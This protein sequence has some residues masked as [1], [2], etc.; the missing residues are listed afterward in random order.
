M[1]SRT[2]A[3]LLAA[4]ALAAGSA[5]AQGFKP[6]RPVELV[7][8]TGPGG[9]SDV[10]ARA[11]N[12]L[13]ESGKLLPVRAVV[14]N[15]PGGGGA[16]AMSYLA[17]RKGESHTLALY[18]TLW[19][20]M[21][22]TSEAARVQFKD[23]TPVANLV[24]D[25]ELMVVKGDAPFRTLADFVEAAKKNPRQLRQTGGSIEARGNLIR[26]LLQRSSGAAWQYIPFPGGGERIAAVLGGHAHLLVAG[27]GEIREHLAAGTLRPIAQVAGTRLPAYAA[28]PTVQESGFNVPH[29]PSMRGVVAPPGMPREAVEYW[30]GVFARLAKS[31]P[32]RKYLAEVDLEENHVGGAGLAKMAEEFVAQR[33][34]IYTEIGIKVVR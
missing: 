23:L 24:N 15:K 13:I 3:A 10:F 20:S 4:L 34:R 8:H 9:G 31:D 17:E 27:P 7:V 6:T 2:A 22:L 33:R 11:L 26:Q 19:M 5:A 30:E 16:V 25:N 21:G 12:N 18:T 32:W 28:I 1:R 29:L 14:V